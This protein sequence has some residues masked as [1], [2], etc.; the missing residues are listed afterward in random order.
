[1]TKTEIL[2]P[3]IE[4]LTRSAY[5][6][7]P[8]TERQ[9]AD[10]AALKPVA[11]VL[12]AQQREKGAPEFLMEETLVYFI[13]RACQNG[14]TETRD[15]LFRILFE[16][17]LPYFRNRFRGFDQQDREDLQNEVL[18]KV[19][20]DLFA[21]DDRGDFMQ[22]RFWKY[23]KARS[24][25]VCRKASLHNDRIESLDTGYLGNGM[26]EGRIC[27]EAEADPV[28]PPEKLA[29]ISEGLAKLPVYLQQVFVMR[30]Y[31]G[32]KIGADNSADDKAGEPTIAAHFGVSGRTIRNWLSKADRL[33]AD[34]RGEA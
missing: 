8:A 6:R 25:D 13:R 3:D 21:P 32:M 17:C 5:K 29:M 19:V 31:L 24:I 30:H 1:M 15:A 7:L 27:L 12:R 23:L 33:L 34:F 22:V 14:D 16:R 11:L 28:L 2:S 20:E 4:L 9:I 26:S 10:A 18:K